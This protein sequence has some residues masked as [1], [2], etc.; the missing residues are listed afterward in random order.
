M[1]DD[2][3]AQGAPAG[4]ELQLPPKM[5]CAAW[6]HPPGIYSP[7]ILPLYSQYGFHL[8][9]KQGWSLFHGMPLLVNQQHGQLSWTLLFLGFG[10]LI[11][12]FVF[13][14]SCTLLC[15]VAQFSFTYGWNF[16]KAVHLPSQN[17]PQSWSRR[18]LTIPKA[19]HYKRKAL[20]GMHQILPGHHGPGWRHPEMGS[21]FGKCI[22]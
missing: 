11:F 8:K 15:S 2:L 10:S 3:E 7:Q 4:T 21:T 17:Q 13:L 5:F 1:H 9:L 18:H 6:L 19:E 20:Q 22:D 16:V 12:P 14:L